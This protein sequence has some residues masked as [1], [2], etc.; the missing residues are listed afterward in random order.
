MTTRLAAVLG[1]ALLIAGAAPAAAGNIDPIPS[2]IKTYDVCS[3]AWERYKR[4]INPLFFVVSED[5]KVC[6]YNY[7]R[8]NGQTYQARERALRRCR[9]VSG[10][11]CE[12]YASF[13]TVRNPGLLS[14]EATN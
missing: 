8:A 9:Q 14:V 11:N 7:R 3:E 10:M 1:A 5:K 2:E 4:E 6:L 13:G 12:V